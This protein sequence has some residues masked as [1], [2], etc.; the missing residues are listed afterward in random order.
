MSARAVVRYELTALGR[1]ALEEDAEEC[2]PCCAWCEEA[3]AEGDAIIA[4][5]A[6]RFIHN[7]PS[8]R[9]GAA[10]RHAEA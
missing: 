5:G 1:A 4:A 7:T 9:A 6:S 2:A 8:C 10:G 3:L